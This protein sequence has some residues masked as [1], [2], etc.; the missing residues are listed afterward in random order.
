[1]DAFTVSSTTDNSILYV[2]VASRFPM[3]VSY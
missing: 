2:V 3:I 1:V